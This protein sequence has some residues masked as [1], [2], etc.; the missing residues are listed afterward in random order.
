MPLLRI[1][2]LAMCVQSP[3]EVGSSG[4]A[5]GADIPDNAASPDRFA[6]LHSNA[7]HVQIHRF[8]PLAMIDSYR[9][10]MQRKLA[11]QAHDP[12]CG[13]MNR[14]AGSTA[15]IEPAMKV[16]GGFAVV[17]ALNAERRGQ[18]AFQGRLNG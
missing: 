12:G 6:R 11:G 17:Q 7:G 9:P 2:W 13:S 8:K 18:A 16:S 1:H 15:L 14:S 5:S 3:V 10:A 4:A